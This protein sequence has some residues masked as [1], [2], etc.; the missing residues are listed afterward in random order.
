MPSIF[1]KIVSNEIPSYKVY[2]NENFLYLLT[3]G[4]IRRH[5]LSG[6]DLTDRVK[7]LQRKTQTVDLS[8]SYEELKLHFRKYTIENNV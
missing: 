2:E 8:V 1:S 6:G 5:L 7:L 3:D 4:D